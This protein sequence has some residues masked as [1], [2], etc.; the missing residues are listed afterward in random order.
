MKGKAENIFAS[1]AIHL[2]RR[3]RHPVPPLPL[4][5]EIRDENDA[6]H[7]RFVEPASPPPLSQVPSEIGFGVTSL[8]QSSYP[9]HP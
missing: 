6:I 1:V 4:P 5:I 7:G 3:F 8:Q 2:L 9:W